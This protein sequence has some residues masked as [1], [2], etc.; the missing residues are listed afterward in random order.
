M[1][2][3]L[4]EDTLYT[5][6][7]FI[8]QS[9][10]YPLEREILLAD[11]DRQVFKTVK[12]VAEHTITQK[13]VNANKLIIEGF[14]KISVFYQPPAGANL[15]VIS[16]KIPFQKQFE[17]SSPVQPPYFI[18]VRGETQYVNT[19]AIN[20][21]RIDIR[22]IYSFTVKGY[23][24]RQLSVAT[25]VNSTAVC[26]DSEEVI[27]FCLCGQGTRQFSVEDEISVDGEL[28][29]I[30]N[31]TAK[32]SNMTITAYRDKV[33]VKGEITA[34]IVYTLSESMQIYK[35]TKNFMYNQVV[36][37]LGI[38]ENNAAYADFSII[39]FTVT[40]NPETK[41]INCMV[42]ARLDVRAFRKTSV[43][44]VC[45]AFSKSW[46]YTKEVRQ[47]VYDENIQTIYKNVSVTV[48]DTIG[49][50]YETAYCFA[51]AS[52][53]Q[54]TL[55]DDTPVLKSRITVSSI[56]KNAQGE[57]EC[58]TKSEDITIATGS[59]II[60][61]N[62]YVLQI[63]PS[64]CIANISGETMKVKAGM[65]LSG[66]EICRNTLNTLQ[67]FEENTD[68]PSP[69]NSNALILY[70]G[71]K[72]EKLFD[73]ALRHKTDIGRILEENGLEGKTLT[74]DKMLF[75]PAFGQ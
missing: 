37:V 34:E 20:P 62:E 33:N 32:N 54:I 8:E 75:I 51:N 49:P 31:I 56:V 36:D 14:F 60:E 6:G 15:T 50:G 2:N 28:E 47:V 43:I 69:Q 24:R 13:Y 44:A 40:Q 11:Y 25:A 3:Q 18:T 45:D 12:T 63:F 23:N 48:E 21:T 30:L 61:E 46:E 67:A 66:F 53:P 7:K 58:F 10:E 73:I 68:K 59:D 57:F 72:G 64:E 70:Y 19:R 4:L 35:R 42:S 65:V 74:E 29:K 27:H 26:A 39:S 16:K 22:G 38:S 1:P 17:L 41:R 71:K 55:T 52:V 5:T 9:F